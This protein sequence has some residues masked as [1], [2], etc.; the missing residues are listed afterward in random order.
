MH[1]CTCGCASASTGC[2]PSRWSSS[3]ASGRSS[4]PD[5]ALR[6]A[7]GARRRRGDRGRAVP[8][9]GGRPLLQ[10]RRLRREHL[11][12]AAER[13]DLLGGHPAW[14]SSAGCDLV[15]WGLSDLRPARPG[16]AS[17]ASG[18]A[19]S[20]RLLTLRGGDG[21][22]RPRRSGSSATTLGGLTRLLTDDAVP[23]EV[24]ARAGAAALPLLLLTDHVTVIGQGPTM[25]DSPRDEAG[26]S[27]SA[28]ATSGCRSRCARSRS[29]TTWSASTWTRT[30]STGCAGA[31]TFIDDIT[32][33]DLAAALHTG[34]YTPTR[35]RR[36]PRRLH[37]RPWS[38]CRPRC[39]TVRPTCATSRT[40]PGCSPRT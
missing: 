3:S 8:G 1:G 9:V 19:T 7:A 39:A 31:E 23:D 16:R 34:R 6:H 35:R 12:A 37:A 25:T 20:D 29:A 32:D 33:A 4:P 38:A 22:A 18:R 10:V 2:S 11:Q 15:D 24:T 14:P 28:R 26:S 13:R 40:P 30:G 36:G 5:G 17:S 21:R 27:W